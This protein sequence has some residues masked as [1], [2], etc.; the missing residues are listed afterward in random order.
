MNAIHWTRCSQHRLSIKSNPLI[1]SEWSLEVTVLPTVYII[2]REN[3]KGASFW[4]WD[5]ASEIH[6]NTT[7]CSFATHTRLQRG[8]KRQSQHK[9]QKQEGQSPL[10]DRVRLWHLPATAATGC[11]S[12]KST[13][14]HHTVSH[15]DTCKLTWTAWD[16][17]TRH[18]VRD[19]ES[20]Y[21]A[22]NAQTNDS[23]FL[24]DISHKEA[25][26]MQSEFNFACRNN[27]YYCIHHY[28]RETRQI[29][30]G[31]LLYF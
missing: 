22:D 14:L 18:A 25:F 28:S 19:G 2:M 24:S 8:Q 12:L 26:C 29:N 30:G 6:P 23:P 27:E 9:L 16:E 20:T 17:A 15:T 21:V 10:E 13:M 1:R 4:R 3:D 31:T 11:R 7:G 5:T